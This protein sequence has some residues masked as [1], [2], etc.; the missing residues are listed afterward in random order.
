VGDRPKED[1]D[2]WEPVAWAWAEDDAWEEPV[3]G[4]GG[5]VS[6][7]SWSSCRSCS[8]KKMIMA[9]GEIWPKRLTLETTL[10]FGCYKR[11]S[12]VDGWHNY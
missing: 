11:N 4:S 8:A 12:G 2:A 10:I 6:S 5:G 3:D 9:K 1:D 7:S